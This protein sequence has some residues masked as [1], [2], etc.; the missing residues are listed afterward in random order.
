MGIPEKNVHK[1][2]ADNVIREN[3][4]NVVQL[5]MSLRSNEIK[6]SSFLRIDTTLVIIYFL[7]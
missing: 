5:K 3:A 1:N 7:L 2:V 6:I 4:S